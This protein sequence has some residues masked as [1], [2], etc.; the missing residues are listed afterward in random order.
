MS[1]DD[2]LEQLTK[3]DPQKHTFTETLEIW[4]STYEKRM[5]LL[6]K[7]ERKTKLVTIVKYFTTFPCLKPPHAVILVMD[8]YAILQTSIYLKKYF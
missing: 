1:V 6:D 5:N 8:A 7:T 2:T 4:K 3:Y